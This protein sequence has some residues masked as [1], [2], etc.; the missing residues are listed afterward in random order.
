MGYA[1]PGDY[2]GRCEMLLQ[3]VSKPEVN[4]VIHGCTST[5]SHVDVLGLSY[6]PRPYRHL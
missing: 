4:M 3:A 5:R 2:F 6:Y 1:R